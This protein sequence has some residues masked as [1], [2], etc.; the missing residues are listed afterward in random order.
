MGFFL[1]EPLPKSSSGTSRGGESLNPLQTPPRLP[2]LHTGNCESHHKMAV[3]VYS[4]CQCLPCSG[5]AIGSSLGD[6]WGCNTP[7][8]YTKIKGFYYANTGSRKVIRPGYG[9]EI[10][11]VTE[12]GSPWVNL[13]RQCR[14]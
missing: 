10:C 8:T 6:L 5:G 12:I 7:K 3:A 14:L 11:W 13:Y 4:S 2:P 9:L 1:G